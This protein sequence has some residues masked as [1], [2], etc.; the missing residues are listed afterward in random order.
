MIKK[1]KCQFDCYKY[2]LEIKKDRTQNYLNIGG[3]DYFAFYLDPKQ[4]R[5]KGAHSYVFALYEAQEEID[6]PTKVIK[7]SKV[8]DYLEEDGSIS[9]NEDNKRFRNEVEALNNCKG[10]NFQNVIEIDQEGELV[11]MDK[12]SQ[13][14]ICFPFYTMDY[15]ECDLTK[16]FRENEV[17]I[18]QKIELCISLSSG[19]QELYGMGYY[20]R[21]LK[22]D[23]IFM[24]DGSWKIG[25]LGLV[26]TRDSDDDYENE[27]IGPRGW[28]T[29]EAMNKY[30]T[31]G[32]P[33]LN[34]DYS[35]DHQSD[36]F[37]LGMIFWFI[38][39][40]NAPIGCIKERDFLGRNSE[41]FSLIRTMLN[42]TKSRRYANIGEVITNLKRISDRI[43]TVRIK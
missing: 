24:M 26:A 37:Q 29:P 4:P 38:I 32:N 7:I 15:A 3:V 17:G 36:I 13:K 20:H 14:K 41:L 2:R 42:H 40:G 25:D 22:P 11:C 5:N 23:N 33:K 28:T 31:E 8:A 21:D 1:V 6:E 30:L 9:E 39:Q 10:R 27:Y 34:F 43:N 18:S 16:F 35:I 12:H 19:L